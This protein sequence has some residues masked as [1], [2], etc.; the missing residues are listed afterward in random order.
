MASKVNLY[1]FFVWLSFVLIWF[2]CHLDKK[3]VEL[4]RRWLLYYN[5][6]QGYMTANI[7]PCVDLIAATGATLKNLKLNG[8]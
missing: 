5:S 8:E 7:G 4:C 2:I 1:Q 3:A 6:E